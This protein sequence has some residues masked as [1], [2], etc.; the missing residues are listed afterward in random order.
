MPKMPEIRFFYFQN[1]VNLLDVENA[2]YFLSKMPGINLHAQD[3]I[4]LLHAKNA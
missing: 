4:N 3:V 2:S 1:Y